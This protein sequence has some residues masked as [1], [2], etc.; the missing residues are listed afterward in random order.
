MRVF[1][2][3][4]FAFLFC[5]GAALKSQDRLT[6]FQ[7]HFQSSSLGPVQTLESQH[8]RVLWVHPRDE[9]LAEPLLQHMESARTL[10]VEIFGEAAIHPDR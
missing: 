5:S 1:F 10:L 4:A 3:G 9:V 2:V 8:F 6:S 7:D